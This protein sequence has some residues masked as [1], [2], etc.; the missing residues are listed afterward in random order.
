MIWSENLAQIWPSW[1]GPAGPVEPRG[2]GPGLE[3]KT[4]LVNGPGPGRGSWPA[5][6]VR[7]MGLGPRVGSGYGKTRP[8][9]DPDPLPFLVLT[10]ENEKCIR[11]YLI[12]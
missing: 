8:E 2:V 7:V 5:G 1:T 3:K 10:I 6:R 9:S 12:M 11:V 4:R